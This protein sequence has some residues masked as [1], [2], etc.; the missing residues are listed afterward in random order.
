MNFELSDEQVMLRDAAA[1]QLSRRD[2]VGAARAA[3]DGAALPDLWPLARDAGWPGMLVDES[4]G[5]AG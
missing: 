3:R 5:G 1:A 4:L 2:G